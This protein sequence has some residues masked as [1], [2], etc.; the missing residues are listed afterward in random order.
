[1]FRMNKSFPALHF[2]QG[3]ILL[4]IGLSLLFS[5]TPFI[6]LDLDGALDSLVTDGLVLPVFLHAIS[7]LMLLFY[8][9]LTLTISAPKF[10]ASVIVPPPNSN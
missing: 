10:V 5:L 9:V 8:Q 3:C 6:D 4:C 7:I 2:L 1:M